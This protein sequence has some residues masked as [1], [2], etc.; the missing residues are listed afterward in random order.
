M[1]SLHLEHSFIC[2]LLNLLEI[3]FLFVLV[4]SYAYKSCKN[5][6]LKFPPAF[7]SIMLKIYCD[8]FCCCCSSYVGFLKTARL[9]IQFK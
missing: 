6:L 5:E 8:F 2:F 1:I 9:V 3:V 4:I 7:N